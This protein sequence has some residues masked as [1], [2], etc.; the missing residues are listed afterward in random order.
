MKGISNMD[1]A[2]KIL[3]DKINEYITSFN[4]RG[5]DRKFDHKCDRIYFSLT[6]EKFK[7]VKYHFKD[8]Y[9]LGHFIFNEY[10]FSCHY[11]AETD[12]YELI[13]R[14]NDY[15]ED[16]DEQLEYIEKTYG[17]ED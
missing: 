9:W 5:Y 12:C 10:S 15:I 2:V 3:I 16:V 4:A 11:S 14:H 13:A 17:E 6:R 1:S 7:I 8:T